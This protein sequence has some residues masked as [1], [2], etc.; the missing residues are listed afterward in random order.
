MTYIQ[1]ENLSKEHDQIIEAINK[2]TM[3]LVSQ[4]KMA[5][6]YLNDIEG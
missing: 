4:N 1:E 6:D 3:S 2:K 5:V